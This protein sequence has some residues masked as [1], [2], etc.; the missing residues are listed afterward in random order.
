MQSIIQLSFAYWQSRCIDNWLRNIKDVYFKYG[1]ELE[2]IE[3]EHERFDY[4]YKFITSGR[5]NPN[6]R[7]G[8]MN[9]LAISFANPV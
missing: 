6:D 4:L 5:Y 9:L 1:E 3:D 2:A 8:A 7:A